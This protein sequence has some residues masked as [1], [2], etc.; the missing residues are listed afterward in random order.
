MIFALILIGVVGALYLTFPTITTYVQ[1]VE[2]NL[3]PDKI[4]NEN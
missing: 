1:N 3:A 2:R 4:E